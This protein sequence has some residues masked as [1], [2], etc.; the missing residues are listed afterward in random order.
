MAIETIPDEET[1]PTRTS[2]R[3]SGGWFRRLWQRVRLAMAG[4]DDELMLENRTGISWR[5]YHDYHQL[6]IIDAGEYQ[7]YRLARR[8][9]LNVRPVVEGDE[10]EYLVLSLNERIRFV[11]IYRRQMGETMEIY[12]MRVAL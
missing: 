3:R 12:D 10:V 1:P 8:G 5:V 9:S 7:V 2:P 6:G 4:D 11:H